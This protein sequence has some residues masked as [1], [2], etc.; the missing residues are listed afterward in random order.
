[1]TNEDGART[2]GSVKWGV[3]A[4]F[5]YDDEPIYVGQT[6]ESL[7]TRIRRHLTNQRTDAVAMSVLDPF[8]V[9]TIKVWPLRQYQRVVKSGPNRA[10]ADVLAAAVDHLNSLER[11]IFEKAIEDSKFDAILN[12]KDPPMVPHCEYFEPECGALVSEEMF[13]LRAHPDTRV[14]RRAMIIGRLAQ[15]ISERELRSGGL[16]RALMTQAQRLE[17]LARERYYAL[18]GQASVKQRERNEDDEADADDE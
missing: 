6:R 14:A 16:R 3:Y 2:L 12:E 7:G 13:H 9:R 5:D 15:V 10:R 11:M 1:M 4:F 17:W 18:G 8:E